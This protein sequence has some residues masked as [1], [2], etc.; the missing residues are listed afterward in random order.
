MR[1]LNQY[2]IGLHDDFAVQGSTN[3]AEV[4][5][6]EDQESVYTDASR[7]PYDPLSSATPSLSEM[8][9]RGIGI[10]IYHLL[11]YWNHP[12]HAP[13]GHQ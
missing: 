12:S 10:L 9:T 8:Q 4:S 3:V 11:F 13:L 2:S 6:D 1:H 7:E 5:S